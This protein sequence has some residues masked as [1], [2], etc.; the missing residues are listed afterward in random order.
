[1]PT[2]SCMSNIPYRLRYDISAD[3][4]ILSII[5]WIAMA[6]HSTSKRTCGLFQ[7][8]HQVEYRPCDCYHVGRVFGGRCRGLCDVRSIIE[9]YGVWVDHCMLC[10]C[11]YGGVVYIVRFSR[12]IVY[13]VSRIDCFA[14]R[15]QQQEVIIYASF[16]QGYRRHE[17]DRN[18]C[19]VTIG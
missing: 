7:R 19:G 5:S 14:T 6:K 10:Y 12:C 13:T 4:Q 8:I 11:R 9:G 15:Q 18:E 3:E 16:G 17:K 1:M 2:H